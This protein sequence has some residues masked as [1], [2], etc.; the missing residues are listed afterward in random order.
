MKNADLPLSKGSN[1]GS[2]AS[3]GLASGGLKK[4]HHMSGGIYRCPGFLLCKNKRKENL[5]KGKFS[6]LVLQQGLEPW[7]PALKGRCSTY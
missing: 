1:P 2:R 5:P 7:T 4:F 6:F 3:A